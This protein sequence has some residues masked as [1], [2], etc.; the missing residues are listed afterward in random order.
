MSDKKKS[1]PHHPRS[2]PLASQT[3]LGWLLANPRTLEESGNSLWQWM[4]INAHQM[5][6]LW[7]WTCKAMPSHIKWLMHIAPELAVQNVAHDLSSQTSMNQME[8][9]KKYQ[10]CSEK[11]S[12]EKQQQKYQSGYDVS[13]GA[14]T[15]FL[16]STHCQKNH[17]P[18]PQPWWLQN[19]TGDR[20]Q[21]IGDRWG[22]HILYFTAAKHVTISF[23]LIL[24]IYFLLQGLQSI[25]LSQLSQLWK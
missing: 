21:I 18:S 19:E 12:V 17:V 1:A 23:Q 5:N 24:L 15:Y 16:F 13:V 11:K 25:D 20:W 14:H 6:N 4:H 7:Q 2:A 22:F 3:W 9:D 10:C 8:G